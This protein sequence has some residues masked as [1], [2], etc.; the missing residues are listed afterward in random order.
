[1]ESRLNKGI[2]PGYLSKTENFITDSIIKV[3]KNEIKGLGDIELFQYCDIR[4][5]FISKSPTT[6]VGLTF[7]ENLAKVLGTFSNLNVRSEEIRGGEDES[8]IMKKWENYQKELS[9]LTQVEEAQKVFGNN[10]VRF[11]DDLEPVIVSLEDK[12]KK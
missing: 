2:L 9:R 1:L 7:D 10:Y 8:S 3:R 5:Q 6:Y 12:L 4:S 11:L